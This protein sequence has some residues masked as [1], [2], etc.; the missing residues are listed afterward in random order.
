MKFLLFAM[1]ILLA[2]VF[3]PLFMLVV[4]ALGLDLKEEA[5]W[6]IARYAEQLKTYLVLV[7]IETQTPEE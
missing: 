4:V 1:G 3:V 7:E 2:V 5:Q 6:I